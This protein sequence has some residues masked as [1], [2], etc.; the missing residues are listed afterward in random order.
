MSLSIKGMD[1]PLNPYKIM[2][3]NLALMIRCN[4]GS[5]KPSLMVGYTWVITSRTVAPLLTW[6]DLNP[7]MDKE[8]HT[9]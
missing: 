6:I 9:P 1:N 2:G 4:D 8:S 7:S 5:G 3:C